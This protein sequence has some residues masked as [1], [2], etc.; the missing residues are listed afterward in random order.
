[1]RLQ[2]AS[3]VRLSCASSEAPTA[4]SV[5]LLLPTLSV[6]ADAVS[7]ATCGC[8]SDKVVKKKPATTKQEPPASMAPGAAPCTRRSLIMAK[9]IVSD[10]PTVASVVDVS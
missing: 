6:T 1:M 4:A 8:C 7:D 5:V 3:L 9:G 10:K 2:A